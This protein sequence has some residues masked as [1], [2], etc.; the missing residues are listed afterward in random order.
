[1]HMKP[2]WVRWSV[3]AIAFT[4]AAYLFWKV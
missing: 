4:M 1:L 2:I 3:I